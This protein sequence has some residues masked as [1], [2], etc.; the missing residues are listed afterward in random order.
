MKQPP[1]NPFENLRIHLVERI[2]RGY[3]ELHP[4]MHLV[5]L[6]WV[7]ATKDLAVE[8]NHCEPDGLLISRGY[9]IIGVDPEV[10]LDEVIEFLPEDILKE[11]LSKSNESPK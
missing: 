9:Y 6:G 2:W 4:G 11:F 3:K 5:D 7:A 10:T 1:Q 8:V